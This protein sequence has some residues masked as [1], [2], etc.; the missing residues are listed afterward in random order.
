RA[1]L[2]AEGDVVYDDPTDPFE[3]NVDG[4][5][6][7]LLQ[8][9]V[10]FIGGERPVLFKAR[11]EREIRTV[12]LLLDKYPAMRGVIVGG[13]QAF[14]VADELARRQVPVLVGSM[15][16]PTGDR[17]DPITAGWENAARLHQAG[18]KVSFTTQYV[19]NTT[20]VRN[21]PYHAA[22]AVAYGLPQETALRAVTLSAAEILGVADQMG[23]LEPGKR[24]DFIVTDGDPLQIVTQVERVWIGGEEQS[25]ETRHTRL[26]E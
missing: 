13:D 6:R 11:T 2:F 18:V 5:S 4:G 12:L 3:A 10:P 24:A 14:R 1:K 8:A 25:M 17:D 23:S 7:I 16:T 21:L 26:N 20:D 22:R 19:P 9:M 15:I